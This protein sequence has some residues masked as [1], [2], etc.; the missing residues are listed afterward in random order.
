MLRGCAQAA[1]ATGPDR[2]CNAV[3]PTCDTGAV[4]EDAAV[5]PVESERQERER[6]WRAGMN[7]GRGRKL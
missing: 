6:K 3:A 7:E 1:A 5:V 4:L 2:A